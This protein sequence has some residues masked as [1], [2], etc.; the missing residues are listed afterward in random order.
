VTLCY[1]IHVA[2]GCDNISDIAFVG[3]NT[4]DN[5][6]LHKLQILKES[7]T[8]LEIDYCVNISDEGII[9]LEHLQ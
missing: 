9:E 8:S 3:C 7:L 5:E 6:A 2:E 1:N 4:I